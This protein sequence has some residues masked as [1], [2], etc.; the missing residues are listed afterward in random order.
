MRKF[1]ALLA[2]SSTDNL[3]SRKQPKALT[4]LSGSLSGK[5]LGLVMA[6]LTIGGSV[7]AQ[8]NHTVSFTGAT[9]D[10]NAAEKFSAAAGSTDYYITF[11]ATYMYFAAFRT[12]GSFNDADNF[13][14]FIDTDPRN[15]ITAGNGTTAGRVYNNVTPTLPFAADYSIRMEGSYNDPLYLYN[16]SWTSTLLDGTTFTPGTSGTDYFRSTTAREIRIPLQKLGNPASVYVSVFMG[17]NG[18]IFSSA[19]GTNVA[20]SG[21]PTITGYFGSFPV[22]KSGIT[23]VS[24]RT[25]NTSAA[26]GGGTAISNLTLASSGNITSGDYGDITISGT[27]T[28]VNST[29]SFTG[30]LTLATGST[31]NKIDVSTFTLNIGGAGTNSSGSAGTITAAMS[32][33]TGTF[34]NSAGTYNFL[35]NGVVNGTNLTKKFGASTTV[36][37]GGAIN[38]STATGIDGIFQI[39]TG[40]SVN[41]NPPTYAST[42]ALI[43]NTGTTYTASTEWTPNVTSGA[44]YPGKVTV[45]NNTSLN[46]GA[47]STFRQAAGLITIGSGS[48]LTLSSVSGGDLRIAG[49]LTNNNSGT[50]AGLV[51]GGRAVFV[52]GTG[53]YTKAGTDNLDFLIFGSASTLTLASGTN[54]SLTNT[55][56]TGCLQFNAAGSIFMGGTNTVTIVAGGTVGGTTAGSIGGTA[57]TTSILN[58]PGACT[59][60]PGGIVTVSTNVGILVNAGLTIS[61]AGRLSAGY[62]QIN[63]GGFIGG[64]NPVVYPGSSTLI[65]NNSSGTYGVQALEWP[66]VTGP[67]NVTVNANGGTGITFGTNNITARTITGTLTLNQ[68]ISLT[69]AGPAALTV[70]TTVAN[71]TAAISGTGA[72]SQSASGS[73][74]TA[75]TSGVNGTLTTSGTITLPTTTSFTFNGTASQVTGALLPATVGALTINNT[76]GGT[77]GVTIT[78]SALTITNTTTLTAG[79]LILPTVG[80]NLVTFSGAI[81]GTS[82]TV[83]GSS[84]SNIVTSTNLSS[85]FNLS[86]TT[87][88]QALNNWTCTP[89]IFGSIGSYGLNTP[90]SISGTLLLGTANQTELRV[91]AGGSITMLSGSTFNNGPQT[92]YGTIEGAGNFTLNSGATLITG[93]GTGLQSTGTTVNTN[94]TIIVSG[95]R[96]FSGG[97]NYTFSNSTTA[98]NIGDALDAAGGTGKTGVITGN[99][100][101][102]NQAATGVTLNAG[103]TITVNSP[104][105]VT[106]G[107]NS[108]A[109]VLTAPATS[110]I[111]GSG[112]VTFLGN[113]ATTG[114]TLITAHANGVNGTFPG[115][116]TFSLTNGAN[117]NTNFTFN[118]AV[119]QTTGALLPATIN[120]LAISNTLASVSPTADVTLSSSVT[121]N[122]T[123]T[124]S[125]RL[126]I[127]ANTLT[128][129]GAA[130][131][132]ANKLVPTSSS[133]LII[134]GSG[135]ITGASPFT[136]GGVS[137]NN[138]TMNRSAQ[139]F[140]VNS[141]MTVNGTFSLT[142]GAVTQSAGLIL[143]GPISFGSGTLAG[144][145]QPFTINGSGAISGSVTATSTP[146]AWSG[147]TM[148]RT[149]ANLTLGSNVT[150]AN[151]TGLTLTAGNITLGAF[152]LTS[153]LSTG[154]LGAGSSS[155]MLVATGAGQAFNTIPTTGFITQTFPI[156]DGTNYTPVTLAFTANTVGGT[157]GARVTASAHPQYQNSGTQTNYLTRYW[158]CTTTG[159]TNYTYTS[160]FRYVAGDING[161]EASIKLNRY[162]SSAWTEDAGST[163]AGN[164][165]TSTTG[166]TQ[167]TGTLNSSDFTGRLEIAAINYSWNG[168]SSNDWATATNWTPNGVPGAL[169]NV[170]INV[171]GSF[172]NCTINSGSKTIASLTLN[173]TGAFAMLSG[174]SLTVTG[175]VTYDGTSGAS[176]A[177]D[178]ASTFIMNSSSL[179]TVA[180]LNYG[181]LNLTGGNRTLASLGTIGICGTYTPGAG[182][183]TTTGSTV[184]FNGS[185]AQT[186]TATNY[187]NL[188]SSSSGARTLA[189]SGT[190]TVAGTFTPGTNTYTVTGSTVAFTATSGTINI[191]LPTVASG[192]SFNILTING[193]GG[194]FALPFSA[195]TQNLSTTLNVTAG[196]FVLNPSTSS[197]ANTVAVGTI[198]VNG[199]TLDDKST[200]SGL[201]TT[202]QVSTGW[203]Q[204]SGVVTNTSTNGTDKIQFT[205]GGATTFTGLTAS[206]S[207]QYFSVQVS[208][209]TTL[210]LASALTVNGLSGTNLTVDAGSTLNAAANIISTNTASSNFTVNGTFKT[211]NTA[212][213]V[214][215]S[216]TALNTTT[217][218]PTF[219]LGSASTIEYTSGSTATITGVTGYAN[220]LVSGSGT[221]TF[222]NSSTLSGNYSQS[223]GTVNFVNG[224]SAF[225]M[226]IGGNFT[227]SAGTFNVTGSSATAGATI[228]VTG[229]TSVFS[230]IMEANSSNT[231][232][233]VLFQANGN[234]TFTGT[235]TTSSFDWMSGGSGGTIYNITFGIKGNFNWTG[236]GKAY[237]SGSGTAKGFVF[238]GAG[239]SASPQTLTYAGAA[240]DYGNIFAVNAGTYV[241]LLSNIAIGPNTLPYN[242]FTITGTLDAGTFVVSGGSATVNAI[243]TG[244]SLNTGGALITANTAG[245][246]GSVTTLI[247]N[248]NT[249]SNFEF[250]S[251]V[252]NQSMGFT[253]LTITTPASILIS[254]TFGTVTAD[255]NV[256]LGNTATLT[257]NAAAIL[258]ANTRVF[259]F[260]TGGTATINGYIKSASVNTSGALSG[261]TTSSIAST[262]TPTITLG[263]ASTVELNGGAGQFAAARTFPNNLIINNGSGVTEVGSVTV[264]GTL[265]LTLGSITLGANNLT[266][267]NAVGGTPGSTKMVI[268]TSTGEV[269]HT[270]TTTGSYTFPIGDATNYTPVSI[271]LTSGSGFSSAYIGASVTNAKHPNN[272]STTNFLNRYWKINQTGITGAVATATGTYVA[273]DIAGT[274][275]SIKAAQ[276]NGVFN[277][278]TN[279]WIKY[280]ALGSNT[281]TATGATL[282]A[283]STSA[284]TGLTGANPTVSISPTPTV[285]VCTGSASPTLTATAGG[286]ATITY[287][288]SPGGA[289]TASVNP[290]TASAGSTVYTVTITDGNGITA[291]ASTT[292]IVNDPASI[293]ANPSNATVCSPS[294]TSFSVTA[295]G[296]GL[297]YQWQISTNGGTSF[298]N[299][300]NGGVYSGATTNTLAISN[301]AGLTGNQYQVIVSGAAPCAAATSTAATLIV[302]NVPSIS[303]NP[304]NST[305]C[306]P[307]ATSFSVTASGTSLTYQWQISTNNGGSFANITNGGVY[308]GATSNTLAISNSAG[309]TGNQY[310]VIVSG[311]APCA[312]ATSTAATLTVDPTSAGGTATAD[313]AICYGTAPSN[314]TLT[315]NV[316][317]V[318]NWE[319]SLNGTSG[320]TTIS[321]SGST[322]LTSVQ[323][324]T[325]TQNRYYRAVVQSGTCSSANSI[326]VTI[327]VNQFSRWIGT[328]SSDWTDANNWCGGVPTST[329]NVV[330]PSTAPNMPVIS[331]SGNIHDLTINSGGTLTVTGIINLYGNLTEA[332]AGAFNVTAGSLDFEGASMQTTPGFTASTVNVNGAG[333][334]SMAG[335]ITV[336]GSLGLS[337]GNIVLGS[338]ILTLGSGITVTGGSAT[339]HVVES[340]TGYVR[341]LSVNGT[342]PF[343]IGTST[344]SYSPVTITNTT[345]KDWIVQ[346]SSTVP[347]SGTWQ[348]NRD[349]AIQRMWD[350]TPSGTPG[351]TDLSFQYNTGDAGIQGS[352][353]DATASVI[354]NHFNTSTGL[355]EQAGAQQSQS[356]G[357]NTIT[358]SGWTTFSPFVIGM[359]AAPLPVTLLHFSGKKEDKVN[360]LFWTTATEMNNSGFK[361]ERSSDGLHFRSIGFVATQAVSGNSTS[362]LNYNFTD[363]TPGGVKQYYRLKQIDFDGHFKYSPIVV[364][365]SD[366]IDAVRFTVVYPNPVQTRLNVVLEAPAKTSLQLM[367]TN[368]HGQVVRTLSMN[369]EAGTNSTSIDFTG[370]ASGNYLLKAVA[371]DGTVSEVQKVVKQ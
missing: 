204:T 226:T 169:D 291:T 66:S 328:F 107:T 212:G 142:A 227:Q 257:V 287:S 320:W 136:S 144:G 312:A 342:V 47:A 28:L 268:V 275:T 25:Q 316:G 45:Q 97:A 256:T 6:L 199:G 17:F 248:F 31:S 22:Y 341:A 286:D 115:T 266:L 175:A 192:N 129:G 87:G 269:R 32:N 86:F 39:N 91:V 292:V 351:A 346:L 329:T 311:A 181:N 60:N 308:S 193:T 307:S 137:V 280:T 29:T 182:T 302:N 214:G 243:N 15:T 369:V 148:N 113:G 300:T 141:A 147:I 278:A 244:F 333:G 252:A 100:V 183:I 125:G 276:L 81:T 206:A 154:Q 71:A 221:F 347:T 24:F 331:T 63:Q 149:G 104:G 84:T 222:N 38:F 238:N 37:V 339:S 49:G 305:V 85:P 75:N 88:G 23:P 68:N 327:T 364:L 158:S 219:S 64:T 198:N 133:N 7:S 317:S 231:G 350:I 370:L 140:T 274:E 111:N 352:S 96:S 103:T 165:L 43:Y 334:F 11:D 330:I 119:A 76:A 284:F 95:T 173:G 349:R 93:S 65:Y 344:S 220:V 297:N 94:G 146:L 89:S 223:A 166:L 224:S 138:F 72:Y 229:A 69:G 197:A 50:G 33:T 152:N 366:K 90:L 324:G 145:S 174:T 360:K 279:P 348:Y 79:A 309:L 170:T 41:T 210:T 293:S 353:Y 202:L 121:A 126:G 321:S 3:E 139:T 323:M 42:S 340:S 216:T 263:G 253:G 101:F 261:G 106:L 127:G 281:L 109:G 171:P 196:T 294:A 120:N 116:G 12:S 270:T 112:N 363:M 167:A 74:T 151:S 313:Q 304:S 92:S 200:V 259:T 242:T 258:D 338:N 180:A 70:A 108:T 361:V 322:T 225:T 44:G 208:N 189:S 82:G 356:A 191:A 135:S 217:N 156:G 105:S 102:D 20:S 187:N 128:L 186:I 240:P 30:T 332:V 283:G 265:T 34:V 16:G 5:M 132:T 4:M 117:N 13:S 58:L 237:T 357:I 239:T 55:S 241:R 358:V 130:T 46:F 203:N 153:T 118:G 319:Y 277:A 36:A 215:G 56:A 371:A 295:S 134:N 211:S 40:G 162:T 251:T 303:V 178:C 176:A 367:V 368:A 255:A 8:S 282:T 289:T 110:I 207:F 234:A 362:D 83:T 354:V 209:N 230:V 299:I 306:S 2:I 18:G 77:S 61:T 78:N 160:T 267:A 73:F 355:W 264:N 315:N 177:L 301:S 21:T 51:T 245:V 184:N 14:V 9:S 164:V 143:S 201:S 26:N 285:T 335:D 131:F 359:G 310:Q 298:T 57:P 228:T 262:N 336:T 326:V 194:T 254:N 249:G 345:G 246:T 80:G 19:P 157:V 122:G 314:L 190:I 271:N 172:T 213:F 98:Q 54:L 53:T 123:F 296:T 235:S 99:V 250:N 163:A 325:L 27:G 188:T 159:L 52:Q 62:L 35:G 48:S 10:F 260:G 273:G 290:S 318:L 232:S 337:S 233:A 161:T 236:A 114:S 205:G 272:A 343:P 179:Q 185:S 59:W 195:S 247:K 155:S 67:T 168:S 365:S 218:L 288:W 124:N 1:L 150:V